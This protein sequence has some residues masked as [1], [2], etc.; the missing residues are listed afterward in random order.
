MIKI[1]FVISAFNVENYIGKTLNTL[2][3]QENKDFDVLIIDDG[4]TDNTNLIITEFIK[5]NDLQNF[6][7]IH[8]ENGGASSARNKGLSEQ[9]HKL[10]KCTDSSLGQRSTHHYF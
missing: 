9:P 10:C 7:L 6:K 1:S 2:L 5:K 4:S 8:K 3:S